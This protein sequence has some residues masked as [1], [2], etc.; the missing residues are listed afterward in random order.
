MKYEKDIKVRTRKFAIDVI[1]FCSG[2]KKSNVDFD[3]VSQLRRSGTS[4]GAN[5][6]EAKSSSS[7][8]E[9]I[10]FYEIALRSCNETVFWLDVT[11]EGYELNKNM[12]ESI[13][14]ETGEISRVLGSIIVNLKNSN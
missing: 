7:R 3:L 4:V 2:L 13:E 5:V 11:K 10:R 6:M 14:K 1:K 9:L 12:F 8:K